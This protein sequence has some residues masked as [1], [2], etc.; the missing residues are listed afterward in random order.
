MIEAVEN[1]SNPERFWLEIGVFTVGSDPGD[2]GASARINWQAT[3]R[4]SNQGNKYMNL[5]HMGLGD[6]PRIRG[7]YAE[8]EYTN[9]ACARLGEVQ[10]EMLLF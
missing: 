10:S 3:N 1:D 4:M 6:R 5:F 8:H 9:Q 7:G 2:G